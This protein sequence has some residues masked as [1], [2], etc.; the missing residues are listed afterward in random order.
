MQNQF[1]KL[2]R[3]IVGGGFKHPFLMLFIAT[4]ISLAAF[5]QIGK[6]KLKTN[7][8]RLL[9]EEN[10][11]A[12]NTRDLSDKIGGSNGYFSI[13]VSSDNT[14]KL[15]P[16]IEE[17][18]G[19]IEK[20]KTVERVSYK[21]PVEFFKKYRFLLIPNDNLFNIYD[22]ILGWKSEVSPSGVNLMDDEPSGEKSKDSFQK[23][24][25]KSEMESNFKKYGEFHKYHISSDGKSMGM[26]IYTKKGISDIGELKK[27]FE[28]LKK[29]ATKTAKKRGVWVGV[30]G[31]HRSKI[32]SYNVIFSDLN[33]T[34]MVSA[35]LIMLILFISFFK[36]RENNINNLL[37][38]KLTSAIG[39]VFNSF[40]TIL[41]VF[42][43]L[44]IGLLWGF[45]FLPST[46][47]S[48][49]II[50]AFL[51]II[52]FGMGIDYSIHLVK[53]FQTELC[54]N[55]LEDSLLETFQ[56]TGSSVFISGLTT[57]LSLSVLS[58]SGFKGFSEFG[59][60]TAVATLTV[61]LSMYLVLPALLTLGYRFKL[62]RATSS[63]RKKIPFPNK[64]VTLL[65][66]VL[67]AIGLI[68]AIKGMGFDYSFRNLQ[69]NKS[70]V[71]GLR[72][73]NKKQSKVYSSTFSP[74]AVYIADDLKSLTKLNN[75]LAAHKLSKGTNSTIGRFRS[76]RDFSPEIGS[77]NWVRRTNV[78]A[79]LKDELKGRWVK[80]IKN[81][82]RKRWIEKIR[83]WKQPI[84]TPVPINIMPVSIIAPN[85]AKD[86]SGGYLLGIHPAFDRKDGRNAMNFAK[87]L[88]SLKL[89]AGVKGPIGETTLFAEILM[90]VT[91]EVG[92]LVVVTLLG[93]FL[94]VWLNLKSVW[95]ALLVLLPLFSGLAI[96]F[97]ILVIMGIDL[98]LF[99]VL[100]IPALLGMGVDD[101]VHYFKHWRENSRDTR[102]T[103]KELFETLSIT[104]ITT[105]LGYSGMMFAGH[106]GIQSIGVFACLGLFA[107]LLTTLFLMPGIMEVFNKSLR[108]K[109]LGVKN[110]G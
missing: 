11:A 110:E 81:A 8:L 100:V 77:M 48:L 27:L 35:F 17:L 85:T 65:F 58:F 109:Q 4:I 84:A 6:I 45:S 13:L 40:T 87:E 75:M 83:D 20:F 91:S 19:K 73:V 96:S 103:Q 56:S 41:I 22:R 95:G 29:L 10:R 97:G 50:T 23:K 68:I 16:V 90:I 47:G 32:D 37:L 64:K 108:K 7:L 24:E 18:T 76:I 98:N 94:L 86:G 80:K 51:V 105:M 1:K 49:N 61:L 28:R 26:R 52:L 102:K 12:Q 99:S 54:N 72:E 33:I 30:G 67:F 43:P 60:I 62:V 3:V 46:V 36:Y 34:G 55:S 39:S 2:I 71:K 92:L 74:G 69:F 53:R 44:G 70:K 106:P 15:L 104:T 66:F 107:I 101:G 89:P 78:I 88:Y 31:S 79:D 82:D 9:P 57:A 21:W 38:R 63:I 5:T 59:L 14:N 42:L 25:G 93:V